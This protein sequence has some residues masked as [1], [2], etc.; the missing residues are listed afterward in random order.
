MV[1][2]YRIRLRIRRSEFESR[3]GEKFLREN[4]AVRLWETVLF[5]LHA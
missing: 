2:W 3:Q 5:I 1:L 4:K